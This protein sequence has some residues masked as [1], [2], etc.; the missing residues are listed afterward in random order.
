[1]LLH[2]ST[3]SAYDSILNTKL[4]AFLSM[5][6]DGREIYVRCAYNPA[7]ALCSESNYGDA[8]TDTTK[9]PESHTA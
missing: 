6:V 8:F 5:Q 4:T 2:V 9:M 7:I 1:M 3:T